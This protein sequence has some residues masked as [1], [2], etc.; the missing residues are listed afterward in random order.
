MEVMFAIN[1]RGLGNRACL[2][3]DNMSRISSLYHF[4]EVVIGAK[5]RWVGINW[6][7]KCELKGQP[8]EDDAKSH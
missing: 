5:S 3:Q 4:I 6:G 2:D 7:C 8:S 1:E